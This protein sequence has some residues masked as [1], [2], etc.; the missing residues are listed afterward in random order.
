MASVSSCSVELQKRRSLSFHVKA[1]IASFNLPKISY[2]TLRRFSSFYEFLRTVLD[3]RRSLHVHSVN[4]CGESLL[5]WL[6]RFCI[7]DE[8]VA[9]VRFL[10]DHGADV[11]Y[12]HPQDGNNPLMTLAIRAYGLTKTLLT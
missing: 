9:I 7:D 10:C 3:Q 2:F 12:C 11:N 5:Q 1:L 6:C 4:D 8:L